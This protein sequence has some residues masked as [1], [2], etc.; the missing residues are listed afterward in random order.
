[1][2]TLRNILLAMLLMASAACERDFSSAPA[3]GDLTFSADTVSFDTIYA[4][5]ATPTARFTLGMMALYRGDLSTAKADFAVLDKVVP[6]WS[7]TIL[8]NATMYAMTV[9]PTE[10]SLFSS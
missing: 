2:T 8:A 3:M 7:K 1:M 4:G 6:L 10:H 9:S 5:F